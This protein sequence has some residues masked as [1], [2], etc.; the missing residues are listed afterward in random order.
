MLRKILL[1]AA[2]SAALLPQPSYAGGGMGFVAGSMRWAAAA[3]A[4]DP[5]KRCTDINGSQYWFLEYPPNCVPPA[6]PT[7]R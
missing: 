1:G 5:A 3:N 4:T 7:Q 6:Y 2:A